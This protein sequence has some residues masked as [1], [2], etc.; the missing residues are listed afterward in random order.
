MSVNEVA[1][2][3][4]FAP[5][6]ADEEVELRA[7]CRALTL[8]EGF[9]LL[10][11]RC[12]QADHR[13]D[14]IDKV[15]AKLPDLNVQLVELREPITH[16]LDE[17]RDRLTETAPDAV[18]VLGLEY[19]LRTSDEARSSPLIA[20]LNA[21]RNSFPRVVRC[22]MVLWVP[23]YIVTAISRGAPD[24][25]SIRSGLYSFAA[26]PKDSLSTVRSVMAGDWV[27]VQNLTLA[28][29]Q[30]RVESIKSLL[31]DYESLSTEKRDP[32][33]EAG[34][35]FRLGTLLYAV[36]SYEE[37]LAESLASL[38]IAEELG[39]RAQMVDSLNQIGMIHQDR[40]QFETALELYERSLKL[41]EK[42]V[43]PVGLAG[44]LHQIGRIHLERG[45]FDAALEHYERSLKVLAELGDRAG[46]ARSLHQIGNISFNRGDYDAA[47]G[48]Y[49]ESLRI[50]E[51][52]GDRA[53][54]SSSLHNLGM[55]H[56]HRGEYDAA[57]QQFERS[58]TIAKELGSYADVAISQAQLARL[59]IT[60][61]RYSDA[62]QLLM[63][64]L[65]T[66]VPLRLPYAQNAASDLKQLRAKWG[67]ENFDAAWQQAC[68]APVPD[69]LK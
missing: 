41:A 6:V 5:S 33:T 28:E 53:G 19:S 46:V 56:Q 52:I 51:Q 8:G 13:R 37:A 4:P 42:L 47:L 36:S 66:F 60:M 31:A 39:D 24:F 23:E 9:S 16:L 63:A 55:I 68:G 3:E 2:A 22:P 67:E 48:H 27:G 10:F 26:T 50:L 61:E 34:L 40:G 7:L 15:R 57:R 45:E 62:F 20:N 44:T 38:K 14:L 18:F 11:A 32:S 17:L 29:K 35:H 12:N 43:D 25:F 30:E 58:L 49:Q 54:L 64:S 1:L 21:S 69:W 65:A 59:F